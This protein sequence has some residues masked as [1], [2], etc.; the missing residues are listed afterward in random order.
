MEGYGAIPVMEIGGS[1]VAS[2]I[3]APTAEPPG[4]GFTV[5]CVNRIPLDPHWDAES[6]L[7]AFVS[8]GNLL[9]VTDSRAWGVAV[10]GPFDYATGVG[11]YTGDDVGKFEALGGVS[12]REE[13]T[14]RL[15]GQPSEVA[16]LNDADAFGL[17][18][19]A[20]GAGRGFGRVVC[21]TLGSGVGSAFIDRGRVV[22]DGST[23]PPGGEAYR[24]EF[25]G[26]P[27][28]DIVS[29]RAMR[30]QYQALT[31]V[32]V[33]L[34]EMASLARLGDVAATGVWSRAMAT[35]GE[36]LGPWLASFCA[37]ALVVGGAVSGSWDIIAE[38]LRRG[39]F[40]AGKGAGLVPVI[41]AAPGLSS[42]FIGVAVAVQ[43]ALRD[44]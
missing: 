24:I 10:P 26:E 44:G 28:E 1:H 4:H 18:E 19:C 43:A 32:D 40:A 39:L 33:D 23:V 41:R 27:L 36:A 5:E 42:S 29:R 13:L 3:V 16:F 11:L 14:R 17:G 35:L 25:H 34:A 21:L 8:A 37:Q 31:G 30:R 6:L 15:P 20:A 38:P 9:P 2:A 22:S 12:V 7:E